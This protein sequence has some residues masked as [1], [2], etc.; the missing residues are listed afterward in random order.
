MFHF[1]FALTVYHHLFLV[2]KCKTSGY[3][4]S[5]IARETA[6]DIADALYEPN[7]AEHIPGTTNLIADHLSRMRE[8]MDNEVPGELR[9]ARRRVLPVRNAAWW[10]TVKCSRD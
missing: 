7:I 2:I 5:V 1:L 9:G 6:L 8:R 3:G 4:T 10:R